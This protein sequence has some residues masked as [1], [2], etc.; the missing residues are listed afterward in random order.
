MV[1]MVTNQSPARAES[2]LAKKVAAQSVWLKLGALFALA[3]LP[4]ILF[5]WQN[6][7]DGLY[8]QDAYAYFN[9][10]REMFT[11]LAHAQPPPFW[12]P[13]GYP[14]LLNIG[15]A[16]FGNEVA[17]AQAITLLAGAALA[18]V[19]YLLTREIA[20]EKSREVSALVAG[21]LLAL[22][23]QVVQSSIV[24]MAD[25]PALLWATLSAWLL[26]RYRRTLAALWLAGS[27]VTLALAVITRWENLLFALA[28]SSALAAVWITHTIDSKKMARATFISF[29]FAALMV[30]P[31]LIYKFASN[32]PLAGQ[33]WL[34][35]WSPANF[36]A[37]SFD[38][39]DGHF[40]YA[41][42]VGIFYAQ[43]FFHPA[44]LFALLTPGLILGAARVLKNFRADAAV[45]VLML[46][47]L[48]F[49]YF[50][51]AGIPYENFRFGLGFFSPVAALAGVGVG[52]TWEKIYTG[53]GFALRGAC[54]RAQ[55]VRAAFVAIV[56]LALVITIFWEPR[57]L[58]AVLKQKRLE[59]A[60]ADWLARTLPPN[61]TVFT[62]AATGALRTYGALQIADLS[63]ESPDTIVEK[64][65]AA[66]PAY[67]FVNVANI[68]MQWRGRALEQSVRVLRDQL[69]LKEMGGVEGWTL[70][71]IGAAP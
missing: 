22:G 26:L 5:V 16:L 45:P 55:R 6:R 63:E 33:S 60:Q 20:P 58:E 30:A 12:W 1:E 67:L 2:T 69:W 19:T 24:V 11:T 43:V 34:E 48:L 65:R 36:F 38:N 10:A 54:S 50:F 68:E 44:Y 39:V 21:T 37:R 49:T 18:P 71:R 8:G 31:Q 25:A 53:N 66:S 52:W 17:A 32:A 56:V 59:L 40:D 41:L 62:F 57:V 64:V 70:F 9:Y 23:G 46:G 35:S 14:A 28:W 51:L 27:A 29:I 4:R 3:L 13:L 47:W 7:F 61:A 15:L 42:P